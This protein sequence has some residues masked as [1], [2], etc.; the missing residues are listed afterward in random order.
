MVSVHKDK[1]VAA[2]TPAPQ[3]IIG[4]AHISTFSGVKDHAG[5]TEFQYARASPTVLGMIHGHQLP[6]LID[7]GSEICMISEEVARELNIR[8]KRADWKMITADAN[9]SDLSKVTECVPS[10]IHAIVIPVPMFLT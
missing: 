10:N 8:W 3:K 2:R 5:Y 1:R 9:Q 4:I 6:L 7:G